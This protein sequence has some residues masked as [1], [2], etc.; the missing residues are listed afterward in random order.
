MSIN[1]VSD[2]SVWMRQQTG[3]Y[4]QTSQV[5]GSVH[6]P[7]GDEDR[8]RRV[9][10]R[11]GGGMGHAL[12]QTLKQ[13]LQSLPPDTSA[14]GATAIDSDNDRHGDESQVGVVRTD[15]HN[16]MHALFQA[17]R[18]QGQASA[19]NTSPYPSGFDSSRFEGSLSALISQLTSGSGS[20]DTYLSDLENTFNTL[21]QDLWNGPSGGTTGQGAQKVALQDFLST[22]LVNL[23]SSRQPIS[24]RG[25]VVNTQG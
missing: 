14:Q 5:S 23:Q 16:F 19:S 22:L 20:G 2:S 8:G 17:I 21:V 15:M 24:A 3:F 6:A 11:H 10:H 18:S 25:N 4:Q 13:L 9:H 1:P 7:G 12:M